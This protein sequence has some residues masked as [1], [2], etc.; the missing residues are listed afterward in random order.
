MLVNE[1]RVLLVFV[2]Y[3]DKAGIR[4]VVPIIACAVVRHIFSTNG[5]NTREERGGDDVHID[6]RHIRE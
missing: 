1:K 2:L 5:G 3:V 4:H 6:S